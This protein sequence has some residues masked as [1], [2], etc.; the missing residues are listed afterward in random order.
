M[1]WA[2]MAARFA[3]VAWQWPLGSLSVEV[4]HWYRAPDYQPVNASVVERVGKDAGGTFNAWSRYL[5]K[6]NF[7]TSSFIQ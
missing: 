6:A 3:T 1:A 5:Q 4:G 2:A 7:W